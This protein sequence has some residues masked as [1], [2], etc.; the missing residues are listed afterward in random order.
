[1]LA[2]YR[3]DA[4]PVA[5]PGAFERLVNHTPFVYLFAPEGALL[6]LLPPIVPPERMAEVVRRYLR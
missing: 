3:V 4:S 1:M 5:D 2:A 6:T